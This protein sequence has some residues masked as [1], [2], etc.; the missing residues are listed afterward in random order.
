MLLM[1][2]DVLCTFS[3]L[4]TIYKESRRVSVNQV[5]QQGL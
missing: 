4:S 1:K 3:K 5:N 2:N